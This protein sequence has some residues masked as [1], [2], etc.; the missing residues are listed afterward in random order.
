ML[1][2]SILCNN[3]CRHGTMSEPIL[4]Q[5]YLFRAKRILNQN[6]TVAEPIL[7][8]PSATVRSWFTYIRMHLFTFWFSRTNPELKMPAGNDES[9][10]QAWM[11]HSLSWTMHKKQYVPIGKWI[12][13]IFLGV[14]SWIIMPYTSWLFYCRGCWL[15][16]N[17]ECYNHLACTRNGF[18]ITE[19]TRLASSY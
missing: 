2:L 11:R 4:N 5:Y 15:H 13:F 7:L 8:I 16:A 1:S 10:N 6:W 17:N 3:P 12:K 14:Q 19:W 9:N 18:S